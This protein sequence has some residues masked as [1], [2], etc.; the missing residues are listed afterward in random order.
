[1]AQVEVLGVAGK[2]QY[3]LEACHANAAVSQ[4]APW[5]MA[6]GR[7]GVRT[8]KDGDAEDAL[9]HASESLQESF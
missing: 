9:L 6:L 7:A 1:M 8:A 2:L 4:P 5:T 3:A